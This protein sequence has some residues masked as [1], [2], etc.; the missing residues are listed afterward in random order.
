MNSKPSDWAVK[1]AYPEKP[2]AEIA[3]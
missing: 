3:V 2:S 1:K